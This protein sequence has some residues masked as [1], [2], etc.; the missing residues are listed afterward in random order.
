MLGAPSTYCENGLLHMALT[1][2]PLSRQIIKGREGGG[3]WYGGQRDTRNTEFEV[4][5]VHT[6]DELKATALYTSEWLF[7]V[8]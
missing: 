1:L 5:I 6:V 2:A 4:V 7:H 8:L 3:H